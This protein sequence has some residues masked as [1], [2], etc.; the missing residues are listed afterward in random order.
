MSKVYLRFSSQHVQ[1]RVVYILKSVKSY[2]EGERVVM[3]FFGYPVL[4]FGT[5][6]AAVVALAIA[7]SLETWCCGEG[8][9][10]LRRGIYRNVSATI[11][12]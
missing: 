2:G 1:K 8:T 7:N 4:G 6:G 10:T 11:D 3:G 12:R 9:Q 5:G